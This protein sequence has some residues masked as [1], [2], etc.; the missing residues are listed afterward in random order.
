MKILKLLPFVPAL[1]LFHST[2]IAKP[3]EVLV[4]GAGIVGASIA[5]H[6]SKENVKV[7]VIDMQSPASHATLGT[8]AWLNASWAKQ[9]RTYHAFNQQ[10]VKYWH[11]LAK[12]LQIPV[13]WGGSLEWFADP[14]RQ[15][16]LHQQIAQQKSWGEAASIL[17][18]SESIAMQP[19]VNYIA[20]DTV[21]YSANDG[22]VDPVYATQKLLQAAQNNGAKLR[23]P[24]KLQSTGYKDD[25]IIAITSCGEYVIDEIILAVGASSKTIN[26]IAQM[27]IPQRSTPGI[28][29]VTKP[30]STILDKIIV[31]PGV[32]IH[33][34]TD[35]RI[36]LGEQR[37]APNNKAHETRLK[38]MPNQYPSKDLA[39][40]HALPILEMAAKYV[41]QI[42]EAEIESV[43]IGWRPLP[44]DGHP[45]LGYSKKVPHVYIAV[46]HSGVT[47]APIIGQMVAQEVSTGSSIETLA[48]YR[49]HRQ[50]TKIIRY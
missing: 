12:Q 32:H 27:D 44:L 14:T 10:S 39:R 3:K 17:S 46:T 6:L 11:S 18:I 1:F 16:R 31:A 19:H 30:L 36:V 25:L 50:F 45:V 2:V 35:G 34:R 48:P 20:T 47:L 42:A 37:G 22:A 33:Q 29:V 8:F 38:G 26:K 40:Q 15:A 13:K 5:Y 9:P 7:T 43:H 23:Y 49:P 41:P 24:C 28:I 21:A 4:V